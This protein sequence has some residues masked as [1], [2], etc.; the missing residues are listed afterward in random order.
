[1]DGETDVVVVGGGANGCGLARDLALRGLSVVLV[2]KGDLLDP[3]RVRRGY[4]EIQ[5]VADDAEE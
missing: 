5:G 3:S 1:M 4:R 2:E